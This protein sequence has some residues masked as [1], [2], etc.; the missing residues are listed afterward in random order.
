MAIKRARIS[1]KNINRRK[2]MSAIKQYYEAFERLKNNKPINVPIGSK[3]SNDTVALEAGKKR[4]TIK[5]SRE[6]F[7]VLIEEIETYNMKKNEPIAQREA[8][9]NKY[10]TKAKEYKKLYE[11]ALNRELMLLERLNELEKRLPKNKAI[12]NIE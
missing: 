8:E 3:I 1:K 7:V 2:V 12:N 6:V 10:K 11:E 5:K 4:G 9:I